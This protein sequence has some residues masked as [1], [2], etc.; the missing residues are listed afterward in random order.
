MQARRGFGLGLRFEAHTGLRVVDGRIQGT[1]LFRMPPRQDRLSADKKPL[2]AAD[3]DV[4]GKCF[5]SFVSREGE[6]V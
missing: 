2:K 1:G 5:L 6:R 4:P 3:R